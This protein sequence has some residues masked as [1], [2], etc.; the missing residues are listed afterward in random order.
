MLGYPGGPGALKM[1]GGGRKGARSAQGEEGSTV[2][3]LQRGR[4]EPAATGG[5]RGRQGPAATG[6][7]LAPEAGKDR[8]WTLK[9]RKEPALLTP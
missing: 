3:W 7:G 1:E 9:P 4:K 8:I 5:G 6:G 2:C